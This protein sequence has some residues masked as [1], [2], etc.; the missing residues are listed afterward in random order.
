MFPN[1]F[2]GLARKQIACTWAISSPRWSIWG[3]P[4]VWMNAV[5]S[6]FL[7]CCMYEW[8]FSSFLCFWA[9]SGSSDGKVVRYTSVLNCRSLV[10]VS[11]SLVTAKFW[12]VDHFPS[13]L[14]RFVLP[15][16]AGHHVSFYSGGNCIFFSHW[17]WIEG[18]GFCDGNLFRQTNLHPF[19]FPFVFPWLLQDH[20]GWVCSVEQ[21]LRQ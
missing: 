20:L 16:A 8:F 7:Y 11:S 17:C 10:W 15:A 12:S 18:S 6:S 14:K 5:P 4:K 2:P 3:K 21:E 1:S 19:F 13:T 9:L